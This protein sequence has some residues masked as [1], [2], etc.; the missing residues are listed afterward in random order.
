[1]TPLP[2]LELD[3]EWEALTPEQ[4]KYTAKVMQVYAAM[5][6]NMDAQ[7]GTLM[8]TLK[9]TGRDKN[10]LLVFLTDNGANPAQGF[11]YESTPEFWKQFDN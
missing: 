6:A 10:T 2:H 11:Y 3:K 1:D 5:I 8:D 4:Q 7:I 9:Q